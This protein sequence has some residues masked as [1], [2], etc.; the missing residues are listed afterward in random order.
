MAEEIK[1]EKLV[2]KDEKPI[3]G[4]KVIAAGFGRTGTTSFRTAMQTT[5]EIGSCY[6]MFANMQHKDSPFW[7]KAGPG[8]M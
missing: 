1:E 3:T 8:K 7:V 6:H 5:P 2:E 4:L